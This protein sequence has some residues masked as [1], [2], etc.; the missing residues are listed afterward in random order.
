MSRLIHE[1]EPPTRLAVE[2]IIGV[3]NLPLYHHK[4]ILGGQGLPLSRLTRCELMTWHALVSD[5]N[6]SIRSS[7][8]TGQSRE[9]SI[10]GGTLHVW[11]DSRSP[12]GYYWNLAHAFL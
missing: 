11:W 5:R 6:D 12:R 2:V 7:S 4:S 3:V 1:S 8:G 9:K 10:E